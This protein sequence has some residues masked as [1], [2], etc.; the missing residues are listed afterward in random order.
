MQELRAELNRLIRLLISMYQRQLSG[1]SSGSRTSSGGRSGGSTGGS[2][3]SQPSGGSQI[4]GGAPQSGQSLLGQQ[5]QSQPPALPGQAPAPLAPGQSPA[6]TLAPQGA[7]APTAGASKQMVFDCNTWYSPGEV[8]EPVTD[9]NK[10][11]LRSLENYLKNPIDNYV[12]VA[13]PRA[14]YTEFKNEKGVRGTVTDNQPLC[15]P[16]LEDEFNDGRY[17]DFR[18]VDTG[19]EETLREPCFGVLPANT[20][21]DSRRV[22]VCSENPNQNNNNKVKVIFLTKEE[23]DYVKLKRATTGEIKNCE[24]LLAERKAA[25]SATSS[26]AI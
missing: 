23:Y 12:S 25:T 22:D 4:P 10:R 26:S 18:A 11:A 14:L 21:L 13:L 7:L 24:K 19:G 17:I 16:A 1:N 20:N 9:R 3:G 8:G 2:S 15:I 6:D 5:P